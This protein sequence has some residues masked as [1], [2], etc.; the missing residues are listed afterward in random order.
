MQQGKLDKDLIPQ[1]ELWRLALLISPHCLEVA[2]YPPVESEEAIFRSFTLD[3]DATSPLKALEDTIYDNPLLLSDF[4]SID[5]FI[6]TDSMLLVPDDVDED[7]FETILEAGAQIPNH[8]W[9]PIATQASPGATLLMAANEELCRFLTRT[10]FNI[11][12]R[13]PL[14]TLAAL[15]S[16][17]GS[18]M[19]S[20]AIMQ[21]KRMSLITLN[22]M[23]LLSANT[24]T[25]SEP[26]DAVYYIL[27]SRYISGID[28]S[29]HPLYYCG[30]PEATDP[31]MPIM[32]SYTAR[33]MPPDT[34]PL[35]YRASRQ[36]LE[37]HYLLTMLPLCE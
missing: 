23:K 14:G 3:P 18:G 34:L 25:Y 27:A 19:R 15:V 21:R 35:P 16:A 26:I 37:A 17:N 13:H 22:N 4:K 6:D 28:E 8:T 10:F 9:R 31:V 5:G 12:L 20:Y 24:F 1:P 33:L 2:L 32:R 30:N 11:R 36:S 29:E 7:D